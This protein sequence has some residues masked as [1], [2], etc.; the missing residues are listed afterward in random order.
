MAS[1]N[2]RWKSRRRREIPTFPQ[3]RRLLLCFPLSKPQESESSPVGRGK[4]EIPNRRDFHFPTAPMACGARKAKGATEPVLPPDSLSPRVE[5]E[6]M[7]Q[8]S[9]KFRLWP[10]K[11]SLLRCAASLPFSLPAMIL[12]RSHPSRLLCGAPDWCGLDGTRL[13][14]GPTLPDKR[15][16]QASVRAAVG[17]RTFYLALTVEQERI[18]GSIAGMV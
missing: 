10:G 15:E 8:P 12:H 11:T 7:S 2:I 6:R 18:A 1:V 4:V 14:C 13:R 5:Q 9:R 17:N 16:W 3:P